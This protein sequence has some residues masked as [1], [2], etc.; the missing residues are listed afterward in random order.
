MKRRKVTHSST[1]MNA[2]GSFRGPKSRLNPE[3]ST[4]WWEI[5]IQCKEKLKPLY[6]GVIHTRI[7]V[8]AKKCP[9]M[10]RHKLWSLFLSG[11]LPGRQIPSF[12]R[13]KKGPLVSIMCLLS[14]DFCSCPR[15]CQTF[16]QLQR[17]VVEDTWS[18]T[19][20]GALLH[21]EVQSAEMWY[22]NV[23]MN[24]LLVCLSLC[25]STYISDYVS[26]SNSLIFA[27]MEEM[28]RTFCERSK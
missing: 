13:I 14:F 20:T 5:K 18:L 7:G 15:A 19:S 25:L 2:K 17:M 4:F 26:C 12:V 16:L 10:M 22:L 23:V 28:S 9:I 1:R 8:F 11:P 3:V 24:S 6:C 27:T 21:R